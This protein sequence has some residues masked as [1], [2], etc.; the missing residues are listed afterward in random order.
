MELFIRL[1]TEPGDL[2]LDPFCGSGSTGVAA[3]SL[4][5]RFLGIEIDPG[6]FAIAKRRIEEAQ[7]QL[8][9]PLETP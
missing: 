1:H 7:M 4:G 6:Y 8:R 3:I 2:V 9:L 5:R